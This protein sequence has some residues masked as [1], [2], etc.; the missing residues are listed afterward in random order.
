MIGRLYHLG[1]KE[2]KARAEQLLESFDLADAAH[3]TAKTYSGGMRRR[4]DLAGALVARP[5][6]IFLDEPTT[7]LDPRSRMGLWDIIGDRVRHGVTLLL[8][9]QYMEEADR[10]ADDIVVLDR[11][12]AIARGTPDELKRQIGGERLEVAAID[13]DDL[14]VV[15]SILKVV[16]TAEPSVDQDTRR[17]TVP[18]SGGVRALTEAVRQLDA[19]DIQLADIGVRRP[20]LDDVF[21]QLTGHA[22]TEE[23]A[24]AKA[25]GRKA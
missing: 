3:R 5:P 12:K 18:V 17:V 23:E 1:R 6:V 8:T 7:G 20:T 25:K 21:L 4:L 16:G 15:A 13:R 9:T 11:G 24:N 19:A 2:S 22:A 10:L 14:S